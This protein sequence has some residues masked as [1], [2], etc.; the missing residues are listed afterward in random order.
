MGNL[1][2]W[3]VG[4]EIL[5]EAEGIKVSG[6]LIHYTESNRDGHVPL[7]LVLKTSEGMAILRSWDI[8]KLP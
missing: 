6:R 3:T 4:R 5:V 2:S 8:I 7:S 1:L